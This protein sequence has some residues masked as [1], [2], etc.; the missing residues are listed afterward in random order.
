MA[1]GKHQWCDFVAYKFKD[2][3]VQRIAFDKE[4]WE[5]TVFSQAHCFYRNFIAPEIVCPVHYLGIK[6]ETYQISSLYEL[7][8][9]ITFSLKM[10]P[11]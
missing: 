9:T 2:L 4:S 8:F 5:V 11:Q 10:D 1:I 7:L 6:C 3:S